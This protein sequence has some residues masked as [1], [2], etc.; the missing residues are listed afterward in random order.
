MTLVAA[1]LPPVEAWRDHD[2][3][4]LADAEDV[5]VGIL[6]D[7]IVRTL[8]RSPTPLVPEPAPARPL[9]A[10]RMRQL[11]ATTGRQLS[12]PAWAR[13]PPGGHS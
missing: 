9:R 10:E 6:F 7:D 1:A 8:L 11:P 2:A 13:S 3:Q 12:H 4:V 5:I